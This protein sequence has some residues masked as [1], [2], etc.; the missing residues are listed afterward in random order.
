M[1]A[2]GTQQG[3]PH[4]GVVLVS[5]SLHGDGSEEQLST[6]Q[7]ARAASNFTMAHTP[8]SGTPGLPHPPH[9]SQPPLP[10]PRPAHLQPQ[11]H[12]RR[13]IPPRLLLQLGQGKLIHQFKIKL[14]LVPCMLCAASI[15]L[16]MPSWCTVD[17]RWDRS[18][19][20]RLCG[21]PAPMRIV[22]GVPPE[23]CAKGTEGHNTAQIGGFVVRGVT[24]L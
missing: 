7:L 4:L 2:A 9:T 20:C 22:Q 8:S 13:V 23:R 1:L 18:T 6:V 5:G 21:V 10:T 16:G 12:I 19:Q 17:G 15:W 11:R 3:L 24:G 14:L